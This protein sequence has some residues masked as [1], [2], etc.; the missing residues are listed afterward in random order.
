[1]LL[2]EGRLTFNYD[3]EKVQTVLYSQITKRFP[4]QFVKLV[5]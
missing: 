2:D 1:M 5:M 4:P 3:P